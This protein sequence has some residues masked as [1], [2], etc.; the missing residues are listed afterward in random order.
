[1]KRRRVLRVALSA[2]PVVQRRIPAV[3]RDVPTWMTMRMA[4]RAILIAVVVASSAGTNRTSAAPGVVKAHRVA[5]T[6]L[7]PVVVIRAAVPLALVVVLRAVTAAQLALAEAEALAAV[8]R[9]K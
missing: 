8:G 1:M 6:R 5:A 3:A 9:N 4:A 7:A 2:Q